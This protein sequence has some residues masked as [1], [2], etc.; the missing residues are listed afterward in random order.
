MVGNAPRKAGCT[1]FDLDSS[2]LCLNSVQLARLRLS[3]WFDLQSLVQLFS[4]QLDYLCRWP[5]LG[6]QVSERYEKRRSVIQ[7]V[8]ESS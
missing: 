1:S 4:R 8:G 2:D 6:R 7:A 5:F 3:P